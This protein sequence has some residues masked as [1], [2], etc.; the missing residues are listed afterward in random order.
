[1]PAVAKTRIDFMGKRKIFFV[2]SAI[3]G[4]L[5][6]V[7]L[8]TKG[9]TLGIEFRGGTVMTFADGGSATVEDMR[10]SLEAAGVPDTANATIQSTSDGGFIVRTAESDTK[11]ASAAFET[12]ADTLG[13][14]DQETNVT[15][16]GPGWGSNVTQAAL[17]ALAVSI[18]AILVYSSIRFEYKMAVTSVVALIH[19]GLIVLGIY[20]IS[21]R[22]VTPNTIAALLTILGYSLYD[23]III[24]HRIR[25]NAA[26]LNKMTFMDMTNESINQMLMRWVNTG[27]I[28]IIPVACLLFFGGE[29]LRDFAFAMTVGLIAAAYSTVSLA[30]P[31]YAVWKECEPR[32]QALKKKYEA[33]A[34]R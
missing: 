1:V 15:T 32:F 10:N 18:V 22:E 3:L 34:A 19:D 4:L 29:T 8:L 23:T 21:G 9:L 26:G 12:V 7:V 27:L 28:Q 33:R 14:P 17:I 5:S 6:V 2:I 31:L 24:F 25:E 13:L 11:V 20:A 30:S 16:I